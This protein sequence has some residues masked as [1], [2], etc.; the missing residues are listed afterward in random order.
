M[1][2]KRK[3]KREINAIM[4]T[5][6]LESRGQFLYCS[7]T[8]LCILSNYFFY[9]IFKNL[10]H[11]IQGTAEY[12]YILRKCLNTHNN[13]YILGHAI[14][15]HFNNPGILGFEKLLY[16]YPGIFQDFDFKKMKPH[17]LFS[18]HWVLCGA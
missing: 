7:I 12:V 16:R 9:A 4:V 6:W 1:P 14:P 3:L 18:P 17:R 2:V 5:M 10:Y 8:C 13:T 11:Q 15:K